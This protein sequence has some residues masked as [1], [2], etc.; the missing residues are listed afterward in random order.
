MSQTTDQIEAV[1]RSDRLLRLYAYWKGK[2]SKRGFPS[3]QSIDV[4]ELGFVLGNMHLFDV[5]RDPLDFRFRVHA[6]KGVD[7]VGRDMTGRRVSD[8]E[9]E[10]YGRV[11]HDFYA[12]VISHEQPRAI[13]EQGLM[14][15]TRLLKWEGMALPLS[16]DDRT[17]TG[18]LVGFEIL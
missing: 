4:L 13:T 11:V 12:S 9:D 8:Y 18:L 15:E 1:V 14:T 5:E 7:Y 3:R 6:G 16:D 17:I 10:D 2:C